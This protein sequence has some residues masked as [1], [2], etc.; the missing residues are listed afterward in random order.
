M[1]T[2]PKDINTDCGYSK[3]MDPDLV[4]CIFVNSDVCQVAV[5]DIYISIKHCRMA[6]RHESGDLD[7]GHNTTVSENIHINSNRSTD[8]CRDIDPDMALGRPRRQ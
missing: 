1:A 4:F 2:W 3:T 6:L 8:C 7:P 5:M